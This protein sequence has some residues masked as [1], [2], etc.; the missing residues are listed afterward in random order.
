M[1]EAVT[2]TSAVQGQAG[3]L[4]PDLYERL[5]AFAAIALLAILVTAIARGHAQWARVPAGVWLH[6]ATVSVALVLTPVMLLRRRGDP[7]HRLLGWVWGLSMLATAIISF[8]LRLTNHGRF[9][10][11]HILS[12]WTVVQVPIIIWS[13]R[14]R[15]VAR[16]RRAV[17]GMVTG[18][19]IIAGLFTLPFGRLLGRWL[20]GV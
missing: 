6:L 20:M 14:T 16:H 17:R 18:A 11:I 1:G 2:A 19:L 15:N 12:A 4:R 13:A 7:P 5:L 10:I 8:D 9:S 3:P